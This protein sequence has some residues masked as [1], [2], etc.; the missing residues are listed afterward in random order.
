ME[1]EKK[2]TK[3]QKNRPF[4]VSNCTKENCTF[5]STVKSK[6][7]KVFIGIVKAITNVSSVES[8]EMQISDNGIKL[9]VEESKSF[10]TTAYIKKEFFQS[11]V[12]TRP[13]RDEG[14]VIVFGVNLKSFTEFLTAILDN[15]LSEMRIAYYHD[16]NCIS[17]TCE[18][19]DSGVESLLSKG[20]QS[21]FGFHDGMP[22]DEYESIK[23][24]TDYFVK[25]M[26]I[27]DSIDFGVVSPNLYH[28]II[29]N[30]SD[31]H[32][33]LNDFDRTIDEVEIK[34][35]DRKMTFKSIG[36]LQYDA[37][38]KVDKDS[39]IFSKYECKEKSKFAYK[40]S[41][42]K[43]MLKSLLMASKVSLTTHIDGMLKMQL[44]VR[45]DDDEDLAASFIE[46]NIIPNLPED[47]DEDDDEL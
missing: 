12:L 3:K 11:F 37:V 10:Q 6:Y 5:G 39:A 32:G 28:S 2:K 43:A 23:I 8:T 34:V 4:L 13:F 44:M 38:V 20:K 36:I 29:L 41:Y 7:I 47:D 26:D 18:Q 40:F 24:S 45:T 1:E 42:F 30:A 19:R 27:G 33:I 14:N 35:T 22:G 15:D 9:I 31:F 46:Y 16:Q 25:T 17:F 21:G